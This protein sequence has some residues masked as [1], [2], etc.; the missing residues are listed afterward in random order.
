MVRRKR[1]VPVPCSGP[2]LLLGLAVAVAG[3][4]GSANKAAPKVAEAKGEVKTDTKTEAPKKKPSRPVPSAAQ[5]LETAKKYFAP[6][7]AVAESAN[8]PITPEKVALGRVLYYDTRLSKNH[9]LS[10]NSCHKLDDYGV[11][12][13][14][15]S[16]GHKKQ[17][18][19]RN[20]PTVYNAAMHISQF[21]DGRATDVEDQALK[22]VTNPVEM[23]LADE[24]ACVS[25]VK[26]V[27]GY[28]GLFKAA[29]PSDPDPCNPR[30]ISLAIGAFERGLTTPA[31]FDD[32]LNGNMTALNSDALRGLEL[33]IELN[34]VSCHTGPTLGGTMYQ[35][36]G[37]VKP[38]EIKDVGRFKI[39]NKPE[40]KFVFKVPGLRNVAKTAPYLHD[41]S[42]K[43]LGDALDVMAEYQ[44]AKGK[45]SDD[46]KTYLIAFLDSLTG[47]IDQDYIKP[48]ELPASGPDTVKPDPN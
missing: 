40:D 1:P 41:G 14:A 34:C 5:L 39:T 42:A 43:T 28:A 32:F 15:T 23:A 19:E 26:S 20:T 8:N 9:D 45:L 12:H 35:K 4:E 33:F 30:N 13:E 44:L 2:L 10:C 24:A 17:R 6:L 21:W 38:Y 48:P 16:P 31:P 7:P 37:A 46:E 11:D 3:C 25:S 29:F 27:P 47:K 22:P 36:L 18:G